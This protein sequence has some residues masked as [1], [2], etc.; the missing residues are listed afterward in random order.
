[1]LILAVPV[2]PLLAALVRCHTQV[3]ENRDRFPFE[4]PAPADVVGSVRTRKGMVRVVGFDEGHGSRKHP[5]RSGACWSS[6]TS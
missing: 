4:I 1:M 6:F 3:K 5:E 2:T